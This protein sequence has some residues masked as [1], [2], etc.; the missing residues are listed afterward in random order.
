MGKVE[1]RHHRFGETP[2]TYDQRLFDPTDV[3][4]D[5]KWRGGEVGRGFS[6]SSRPLEAVAEMGQSLGEA[7]TIIA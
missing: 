5:L 4:S 7:I 3:A 6:I 2:L 1:L